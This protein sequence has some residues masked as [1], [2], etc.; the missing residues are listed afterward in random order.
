M[1]INYHTNYY[2]YLY[3]SHLNGKSLHT[4]DIPHLKY[5]TT[6]PS[7]DVVKQTGDILCPKYSLKLPPNSHQHETI[8]PV[9]AIIW[10]SSQ[11]SQLLLLTACYNNEHFFDEVIG[12]FFT[13]SAEWVISCHSLRPSPV[14]CSHNLV[15]LWKR[16][17]TELPHRFPNLNMICEG[18]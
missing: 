12:V 16:W 11:S 1:N 17:S 9:T 18:K 2:I 4:D 6:Y 14:F 5:F 8:H 3:I 10:M 7:L 15:R 13:L